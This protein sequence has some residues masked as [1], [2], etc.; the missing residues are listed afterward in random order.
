[1][2]GL[3][4]AGGA[5][6]APRWLVVSCGLAPLLEEIWY[7]GYLLQVLTEAWALWPA[8]ATSG[9]V[10]GG[11]HLLN[12]NPSLLGAINTALMGVMACL[13]VIVTGSL[14]FAVAEHALC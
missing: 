13:G 12:P 2:N 10:F 4:E 5:V 9:L 6:N 11:L 14:W 7:R 8:V 3:L 1:M